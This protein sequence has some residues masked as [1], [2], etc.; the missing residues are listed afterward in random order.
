MVVT[1]RSFWRRCAVGIAAILFL[2]INFQLSRTGAA[3]NSTTSTPQSTSTTTTPKKTTRR[4]RPKPQ[5]VKPVPLPPLDPVP[6]ET[7][8]QNALASFFRA[9]A[10]LESPAADALEPPVVH[11]IHF[12]DSHV[13][14]DYWA[15]AIREK[16]QAR[17]GDAGPGFV[18]P[19]RPWQTI[20]YAEAKS[21]DGQGWR[22]D[23]L[24]PGENDGVV[25]LG[26][27]SLESF[28]QAS[29][30]SALASFSQFEILAAT[31]PGTDCLQVQVDDVGFHDLASHV[32]PVIPG[33][34]PPA[35]VSLVPEPSSRSLGGGAA[36]PPDPPVSPAPV[37]RSKKRRKPVPAVPPYHPWPADSLL[38]L[39]QLRNSTPLA[40]GPHRV[41]IRSSCGGK[42]RLLGMELYSGSKG[43]VYDTDGVNGA[44]LTDVEKP[45]PALRKAL[46]QQ[47]HPALIIVSYGTNDIAT[48]GFTASGYEESAFQIL[49]KLKQDA[50]DASIL[51]TG[52]TDRGSP[53]KVRRTYIQAAQA[54]LQPA[55]RRAA[56]RAGCAYW[57]Q[58]AA[59][60]G[61]GAMTRWVRAGLA[62]YDYVHFSGLGYQKLA[63]MLYDQLM[64]EYGN[65]LK[66]QSSE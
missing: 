19:G 13:A 35:P 4:T 3:Q 22:T 52:P 10:N 18:L 26:G 34:P 54:E 61:P 2:A 40:A 28:R 15:G 1:G 53:R 39:L 66:A 60:G 58:Q 24:R 46:L 8:E 33:G 62:A 48:P 23:G 6:I 12:G 38:D 59:M 57:D 43:I 25:G 56:L 44:R 17:F 41:S 49:S 9:L 21:L 7:G 63:G 5:P 50:G 64:V 51:V 36:D 30:A 55:L 11:I 14:S 45:L 32:E 37:Q 16:L 65:F 27:M 42:A 47:S 20:R 31:T 29:P